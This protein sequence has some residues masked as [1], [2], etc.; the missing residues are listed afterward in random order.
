ME[1]DCEFQI[2]SSS[3]WVQPMRNTGGRVGKMEKPGYLASDFL[4]LVVS[5]VY[6]L[7]L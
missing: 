4:L 5:A 1:T 2:Q 3:G 6:I 7:W